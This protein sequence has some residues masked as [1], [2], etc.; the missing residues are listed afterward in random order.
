M[1]HV[2]SHSPII[3]QETN[4]N[5]QTYMALEI[6]ISYKNAYKLIKK[7]TSFQG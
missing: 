3:N 6:N 4:S 1:W 7:T 5:E 2:I